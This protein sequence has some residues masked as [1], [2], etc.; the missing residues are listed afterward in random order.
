MGTS[1]MTALE[2]E[3]LNISDLIFRPNLTYMLNVVLC[4]HLFDLQ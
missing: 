2:L 3:Y 4:E 1:S